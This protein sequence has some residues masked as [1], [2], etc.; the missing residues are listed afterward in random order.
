MLLVSGSFT[1]TIEHDGSPHALQ[2]FSVSIDVLVRSAATVK[3]F[4]QRERGAYR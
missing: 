2:Y 3:S 4:A 1:L